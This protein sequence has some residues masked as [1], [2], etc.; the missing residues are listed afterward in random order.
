MKYLKGFH[1]LSVHANPHILKSWIAHIWTIIAF[2][3]MHTVTNVKIEYTEEKV[4]ERNKLCY[5]LITPIIMYIH[6]VVTVYVL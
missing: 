2:R 4:F 3:Y 1:K 6:P 5:I